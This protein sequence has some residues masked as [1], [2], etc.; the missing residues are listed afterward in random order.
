MFGPLFI[1]RTI[2][3]LGHS[4]IP[5]AKAP[6]NAPITVVDPNAHPSSHQRLGRQAQK[7]LDSFRLAPDRRLNCVQLLEIAQRFGARLYDIRQAGYT[8]SLVKHD[9]ASG[10]TV[11]ELRDLA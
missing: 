1:Q 9:H 4:I 11:Y 7:I 3:G 6:M 5:P 8:I 2:H 10:L